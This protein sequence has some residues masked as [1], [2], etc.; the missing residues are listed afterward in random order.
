[1]NSD[2]FNQAERAYEQQLPDDDDC[3]TDWYDNKEPVDCKA[4]WEN[5]QKLSVDSARAKVD[6]CQVGAASF[7]AQLVSA[8]IN[9]TK[10]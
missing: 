4:W 3:D 10:E 2:N 9:K 7:P 8:T 1:M 6:T 5:I